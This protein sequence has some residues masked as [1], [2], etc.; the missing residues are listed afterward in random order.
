M[1][2]NDAPGSQSAPK[3]PVEVSISLICT[4]LNEGDNL[5]G[6]LDSIVGQTRPPDEIVFVDGGSHDNTVAILHEYESK[7]PL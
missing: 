3:P 7:L 2:V 5:R 6:L 1:G 4:V